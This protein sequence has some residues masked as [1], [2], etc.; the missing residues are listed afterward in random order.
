MFSSVE[1]LRTKR[2][3]NRLVASSI[4]AILTDTYLVW[5]ERELTVEA[6]NLDDAHRPLEKVHDLAASL[7]HVEKRQVR[8]DYTLRWDGKVYQIERS[9]VTAGLRGADVRMEQRL[10]GTLAVRHGSRYLPVEECAVAEKPKK[11]HPPKTAKRRRTQPRGSDWNKDFDLR[12]GP[13]VWQAAEASG[14][15]ASEEA[16]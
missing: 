4:M 9:A 11:S 14:H 12:K 15:R 13:K 5:W 10:D 16:V 7:S 1:S 6:A 3:N 8:P 2:A